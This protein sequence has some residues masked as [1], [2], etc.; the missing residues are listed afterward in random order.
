M[1]G[2][3]DLDLHDGFEENG[4]RLLHG[5]LEGQ[6]A[7]DFERDVRGID[8]VIFAVVEDGAEIHDWE[9]CQEAPGGGVANSSFDGRNPVLGDRPAENIVDELNSLATFDGLHFDAADTKLSVA[10]GLLFVLA[11][12]VGFPADGFAVRNF[13]RLQGEINVIALVEL[14]DDDFNVLLAGTREQEFLGLRI[15]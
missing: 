2:G 11:F 1:I 4:T 3:V 13:G 10:A 14:G 5:F 12:D 6:R 15:P 7:G 9:S 8:V